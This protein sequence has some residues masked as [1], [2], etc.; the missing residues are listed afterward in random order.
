MISTEA[1]APEWDDLEE[2]MNAVHAVVSGL[3]NFARVRTNLSVH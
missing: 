2:A 1:K 3:V